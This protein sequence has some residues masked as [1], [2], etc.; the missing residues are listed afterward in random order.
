MRHLLLAAVLSL[1]AVASGA[2]DVRVN[3]DRGV[4]S[5][6]ARFEVPAPVPVAL[7]VLT[8]YEQIPRFMPGIKTTLV[9]ER[10]G[11]RTVIEQEALSKFMMFSKSVHL[12]LEISEAAGALSFRDRCRK[13]FA[14][15]EGEW[16]L[17]AREGGTELVY[18]LTA[19]P[20]FDVPRFI[21]KR[22]LERDSKEMIEQLQREIAVRNHP[23]R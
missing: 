23:L 18:T 1:D 14:R 20:S 12:V 7:A 4:Y 2:P 16:R 5:V 3:E 13:S 19:E 9:H 11:G 17:T 8:D 10:G 22:L 15:Y 6:T 21:L